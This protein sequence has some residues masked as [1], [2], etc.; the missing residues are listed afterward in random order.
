VTTRGWLNR[1]GRNVVNLWMTTIPEDC[2]QSCRPRDGDQTQG[3]RYRLQHHREEHRIG[4]TWW[5]NAYP[6]AGVDTPSHLYT[7]S[8]ALSTHW[9]RYF[10]RGK[11]VE[12][13]LERLAAEHGIGADI[14]FGAELLTAAYD[15]AT[16]RW[17]VVVRTADGVETQTCN[18]LVSAVGMVNRPAVPDLPGLD[19]FAGPVIHTAQWQPDVDVTGKRVAVVGTGAGAM[20]LNQPSPIAPRISPCFSGPNSGPCHIFATMTRSPARRVI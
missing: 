20:Q 10:A 3:R 12:E 6:G 14:S 1:I 8:F 9:D 13:Y 19:D 18:V 17:E 4:G 16:A 2:R 7:F 11:Q 15:P 5:E